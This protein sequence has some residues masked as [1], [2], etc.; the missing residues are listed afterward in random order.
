MFGLVRTR[1]SGV[2]FL[3]WGEEGP[4]LAALA[5][6]TGYRGRDPKARSIAA[7]QR[8]LPDLDL[9]PGRRTKPHDGLADAGCLA[10]YALRVL[11]GRAAP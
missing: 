7:A 2:G 5:A 10:V 4:A 8:L 1:P 6:R 9:S 11:A 3:L